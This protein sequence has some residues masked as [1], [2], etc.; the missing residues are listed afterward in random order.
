MAKVNART[1]LNKKALNAIT[2]GFVDAFAAMGERFVEVVKPPD[3]EP[4]GKGLVTTPDW[5]VWAGSKKVAGTASK[6]RAAR[7]NRTGLTLIA[8]EGFP[9]RFQEM[10]TVNHPAQPHVTPAMLQVIPDAAGFIK[11]A[12]R[13]R[14]AGVR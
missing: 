3:A 6:P 12:V 4:F 11:P 5:G 1:V 2:A 14:L 8:G 7:L 9:G 13:R 10:G